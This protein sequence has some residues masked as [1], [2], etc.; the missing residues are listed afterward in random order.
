[1][2][3]AGVRGEVLVVEDDF[4]IGEALRELLENEGYGVTWASNGLEALAYLRTRTPGLILLDLMMPVMDG[5]EFRTAQRGDPALA[6]VPVI[7]LSADHGLERKISDLS[8]QA[9]LPKPFA[10][11][12]LLAAVSQH[13]SR[14]APGLAAAGET[15]A[16]TSPHAPRAATPRPPRTR[17][18]GGGPP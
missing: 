12:A 13:C 9:W 15:A 8:V 14:A 6:R 16:P 1:M 10:L 7:V 4:A 3:G 2:D 17:P 18:V 11:D 5:W